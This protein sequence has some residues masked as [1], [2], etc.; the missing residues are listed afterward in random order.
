MTVAPLAAANDRSSDSMFRQLDGPDQCPHLVVSSRRIP[1]REC[2][3]P[4]CLH[5]LAMKQSR[6]C[7]PWFADAMQVSMPAREVDVPDRARIGPAP[8]DFLLRDDLHRSYFWRAGNRPGREARAQ[9]IER[10]LVR[11]KIAF[12]MAHDMHHMRITVDGHETWNAHRCPACEPARHRC[13][14]DRPA[15]C[16][17]L[18]PSHR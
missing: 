12:D 10:G 11:P 17:R 8:V 13:G 6:P 5:P 14:P 3:P 18:V 1:L 9:S 7:R 2:C 16:A 4:P 15:S